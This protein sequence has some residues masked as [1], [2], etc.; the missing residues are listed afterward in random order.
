MRMSRK[1]AFVF[2]TWPYELNL[3]QNK[4]V[5]DLLQ[6]YMKSILKRQTKLTYGQIRHTLL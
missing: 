6:D 4:N 1:L 2:A 5:L 3:K